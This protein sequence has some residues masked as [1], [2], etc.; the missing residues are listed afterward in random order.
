MIVTKSRKATLSG[1]EN[2]IFFVMA[3]ALC[4]LEWANG[5]RAAYS[6]T[7]ANVS[8]RQKFLFLTCIVFL[9]MYSNVFISWYYPV[10]LFNGRKSRAGQFL[11]WAG[12][13]AFHWR[14]HVGE[15]GQCD[16][17]AEFWEWAIIDYSKGNSPMASLLA[18]WEPYYLKVANGELVS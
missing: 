15:D 14:A 17:E 6:L 5:R 18:F 9:N 8:I 4:L 10:S 1:E 2:S 7:K 11:M 12:H 3:S 13:E 16:G